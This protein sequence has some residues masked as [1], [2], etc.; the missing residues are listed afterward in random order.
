MV[1]QGEKATKVIWP[2][3]LA[4]TRKPCSSSLDVLAVSRKKLPAACSVALATFGAV[5]TH[6]VT[7]APTLSVPLSA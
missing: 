1:W 6:T 3:C 7:P 4:R 5:T 2:R